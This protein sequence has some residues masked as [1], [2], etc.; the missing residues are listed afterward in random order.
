MQ[1]EDPLSKAEFEVAEFTGI[2]HFCVLHTE[3]IKVN[4]L[5]HD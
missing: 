1:Q 2:C 3:G 4:Y 5:H